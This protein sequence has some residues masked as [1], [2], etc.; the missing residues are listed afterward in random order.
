MFN[1]ILKCGF[2]II[3][4]KSDVFKELVLYL[5]M[6]VIVAIGLQ[7]LGTMEVNIS[8]HNKLRAIIIVKADNHGINEKAHSLWEMK[9]LVC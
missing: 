1:I 8:L 7:I 9:L 6:K 5:F 3:K 4:T 2:C